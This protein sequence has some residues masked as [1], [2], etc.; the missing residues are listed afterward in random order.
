M[1]RSSRKVRSGSVKVIGRLG[2]E[3][4]RG[5]PP[6]FFP[7]DCSFTLTRRFFGKLLIK[8]NCCKLTAAQALRVEGET[9]ARAFF[10]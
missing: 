3:N 8:F 7:L 9:V 6:D 4:F 10:P 2:S 1:C 5:R